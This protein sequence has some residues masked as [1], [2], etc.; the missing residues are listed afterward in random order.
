MVENRSKDQSNSFKF[1]V[2]PS[3][4]KRLEEQAGEMKTISEIFEIHFRSGP[5]SQMRLCWAKRKA[6]L[7]EVSLVWRRSCLITILW[8]CFSNCDYSMSKIN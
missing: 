4:G 2:C 8:C 6:V 5:L 7:Y 1:F 3:F